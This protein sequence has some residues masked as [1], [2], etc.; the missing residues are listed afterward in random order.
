MLQQVSRNQTRR[1]TGSPRCNNAPF[2]SG[3]LLRQESGLIS[4]HN[5]ALPDQYAGNG[6]LVD[7]CRK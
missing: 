3:S 1:S 7:R 6:Q 5:E 2:E 4:W